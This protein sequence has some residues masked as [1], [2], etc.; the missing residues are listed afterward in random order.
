MALYHYESRLICFFNF[1]RYVLS[2]K[3]RKKP[4]NRAIFDV[5]SKKKK[6]DQPYPTFYTLS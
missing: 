6:Y 3:S 1:Q 5:R 2:E 4:E